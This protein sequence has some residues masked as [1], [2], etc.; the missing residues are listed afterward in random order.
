MEGAVVQL[1]AL[2]LCSVVSFFPLC[3]V[4]IGLASDQTSWKASET[5][6]VMCGFG[7][8]ITLPCLLLYL[9]DV[10]HRIG[11]ETD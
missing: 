1:V 9:P 3:F 7:L 8:G 5:K 6:L 11:N 10:P 4:K 2:T